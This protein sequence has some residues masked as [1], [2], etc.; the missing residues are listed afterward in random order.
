ME[1]TLVA[2]VGFDKSVIFGILPLARDE[3]KDLFCF[4]FLLLFS[5]LHD[6]P[7]NLYFCSP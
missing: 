1:R 4:F 7:R 6:S 3:M 2:Y 5:S